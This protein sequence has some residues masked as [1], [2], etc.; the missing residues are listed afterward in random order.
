MASLN[1]GD[2]H[3]YIGGGTINGGFGKDIEATY[4]G[5]VKTSRGTVTTLQSLSINLHHNFYYTLYKQLEDGE[6]DNELIKRV[7]S[8]K[9]EIVGP[10][11]YDK[12]DLYEKQKNDD[13]SKIIETF[14]NTKSSKI[15]GELHTFDIEEF[16]KVVNYPWFKE[17]YL[18]IPEEKNRLGRDFL[19]KSDKRGK[20]T[21]IGDLF[22][23]PGDVFIEIFSDNLF[24]RNNKQNKAM[25]YCVGPNA[26][27]G[28]C[29]LLLFYESIKKIGINIASAINLYNK[30]K[31]DTKKNG[32]IIDYVRICL[33][34]GQAY[35]HPSSNILEIA[36]N[37]VQGILT[38]DNSG[39]EYN[40]AYVQNSTDKDDAES[41]FEKA[42]KKIQTL[43]LP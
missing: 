31:N 10:T 23:L 32:T 3:L 21:P 36:E 13:I 18:Y 26:S 43:P 9:Y 25:I 1:A 15:L 8:Y 38:I 22:F 11:H 14:N 40:F 42:Y 29:T 7:D 24:P 37:L 6:K 27:S 41:I 34:S 17:I 2:A 19:L 4:R 39:V 28:N 16:K 30:K 5:D 33:I 12:D 20:E 35:K